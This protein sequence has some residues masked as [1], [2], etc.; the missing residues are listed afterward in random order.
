MPIDLYHMDASSACRSVRLTAKMVGVE[1]NLKVLDLQAGEQM[2][3]EFIKINPQHNIPTLVDD[4]FVL[5]ESRAICG[6]LVHKYAKDDTLY[7][8]DP[9]VRAL[10]D[11]RLYFDMGVFYQSFGKVYYPVMFGGATQ[12]DETAKNDFANAVGFLDTFL[13]QNKYAAGD[14]LTIADICLMASAATFEATD[15]H[16]FDKYPTI[17]N[18]MEACKSELVDYQETNQVGA[19]VFGKMAESAMA[20]MG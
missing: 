11:Q 18:W 3:P 16:V 4:G 20:K 15:A 17:K 7:P 12:F 8:K 2:K 19:E 5:N 10:V 13:S 9:K 6:Y 1:L 14:H